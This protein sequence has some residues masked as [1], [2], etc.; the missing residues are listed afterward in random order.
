MATVLQDTMIQSI[1]AEGHHR[2]GWKEGDDPASVLDVASP[3]LPASPGSSEGHV[4]FQLGTGLRK[5]Q[6]P[7]GK[8][9]RIHLGLSGESKGLFTPKAGRAEGFP[10]PH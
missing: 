4:G 5:S 8:H 1:F 9:V 6:V 10:L 3:P 7:W 2:A